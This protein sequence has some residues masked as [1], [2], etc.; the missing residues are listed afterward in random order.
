MVKNKGIEEAKSSIP[1]IKNK[2]I[3][4][5]NVTAFNAEISFFIAIFAVTSTLETDNDRYIYIQ[6]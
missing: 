6:R 2:V 4:K 1:I 3:T 5:V